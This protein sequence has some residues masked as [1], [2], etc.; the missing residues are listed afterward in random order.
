MGGKA[1]GAKK[2]RKKKRQKERKQERKQE[3]TKKRK[4]ERN[5]AC[6]M[7]GSNRIKEGKKQWRKRE[8]HRFFFRDL[9]GKG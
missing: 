3:R 9:L 1:T 7:F 4:K 5:S 6:K 8:Y 2:E